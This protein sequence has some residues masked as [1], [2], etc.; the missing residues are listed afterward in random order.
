[1]IRCNTLPK[2]DR[3]HIRKVMVLYTYVDLLE[4]KEC[5]LASQTYRLP[6]GELA[7][8][9]WTW[10]RGDTLPELPTLGGFRVMAV[11]DAQTMT[12]VTRSMLVAVEQRIRT[13]HR[14]YL[15]LIGE[16]PVGYGWSA[17]GETDFGI[18]PV[19]FRVPPANRYLCDFATFPEWR[20]HGVYPRLLQAIIDQEQGST[21]RFWILHQRTNM[22]SARG[23]AKAGFAH[24][25]E[26]WFLT[27]GGFGIASAG[28][29]LRAEAGAQLLGLPLIS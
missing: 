21:E 27:Q 16:S 13:G 5:G 1:M 18:P 9:L 22:A 20:G 29:A 19:P 23:I 25:A 3:P 11:A 24:V 17:T 2:T 28:A 7:G 8:W 26:I 6:V 12:A 4:S 10:W 15:A 14:P